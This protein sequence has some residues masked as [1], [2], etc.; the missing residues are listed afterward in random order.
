MINYIIRRLLLFFPVLF[1]VA[2][3][4][5]SLIRMIPGDPA[6]VMLGEF[7][8]EE[9]VEALR[10]S[11]GLDQPIWVQFGHWAGN[12]LKLNLGE[13]LFY[14]EA[15]LSV[16][17]RHLMPTFSIVIL[18]MVISLVI[19][20]PVGIICAVKRGTWVD[21]LLMSAAF[22]GLSMPSFWTGLILITIFAVGLSWFP[23]SGFVPLSEGLVPWLQSI[24][25]PSIALGITQVGVVARM[26]RHSMIDALQQDYI[27]TARSKGIKFYR[28]LLHHAFP[29]TLIPLLTLIGTGFA[30]LM[31]GGVIVETVFNIRGLGWLTV[32]AVYRRD[33]PLVQ[34]C[35]LIIALIYSFI[36]LLVDLSYG[37]VDPRIRYE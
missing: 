19:A 30:L 14:N 28:I 27:R 8:P 17:G 26:L 10:E 37:I 31:A 32:N 13:S 29:N 24:I 33:F 3:V 15:V 5:F 6:I 34:G 25:L 20:I 35:I 1:V 22:V 7:A 2:I 12:A 16:I 11:L 9:Q 4:V 21:S 18:A 36:N 23:S